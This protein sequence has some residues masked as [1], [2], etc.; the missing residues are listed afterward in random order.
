MSRFSRDSDLSGKAY[1]HG[2]PVTIENFVEWKK[3]FDA[4]RAEK[5]KQEAQQRKKSVTYL[6]EQQQ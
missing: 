6:A 5:A 1:L 4:D 3:K 2:T